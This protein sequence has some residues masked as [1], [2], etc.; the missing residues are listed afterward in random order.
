MILELIPEEDVIKIQLVPKEDILEKRKKRVAAKGIWRKEINPIFEKVNFCHI[1]LKPK[2]IKPEHQQIV[3]QHIVRKV[4]VV[5]EI[6]I[7]GTPSSQLL[8]T[9][10]PEERIKI[11]K[12]K[13]FLQI[14]NIKL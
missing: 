2:T 14:K 4:V 1:I 8:R 12:L 11:I 10:Y 6:G 13:T 5:P 7:V 3:H 9:K